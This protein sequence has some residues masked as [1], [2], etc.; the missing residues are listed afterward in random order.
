MLTAIDQTNLNIESAIKILR[1]IQDDSTIRTLTKLN[2][3]MDKALLDQDLVGDH[4]QLELQ[5]KIYY[6]CESDYQSREFRH[7]L[8]QVSNDFIDQT[9]LVLDNMINDHMGPQYK[10]AFKKLKYD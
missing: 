10:N 9:F 5:G 7:R 3:N 4:V 2:K 8:F 6:I 1:G